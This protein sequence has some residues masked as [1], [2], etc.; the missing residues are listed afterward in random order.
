MTKVEETRLLMNTMILLVSG[1]MVFV[2]WMVGREMVGL[3]ECR[4]MS[5]A[6]VCL[7]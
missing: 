4:I 2:G 1:V 7:G 6:S 5:R 3:G